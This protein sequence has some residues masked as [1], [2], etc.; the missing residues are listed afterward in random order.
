VAC[1]AAGAANTIPSI[2]AHAASKYLVIKLP[3]P[4]SMIRR[5]RCRA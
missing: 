3:L 2:P 4:T 5:D 1:A